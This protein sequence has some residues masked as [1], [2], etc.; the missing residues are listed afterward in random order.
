MTAVDREQVLAYRLAGHHLHE[1]T[2]A[3]TAIAA[4]GLQESPPGWAPVAL[5]ARS[6]DALPTGRSVALVNAMRNAPHYVPRA[7]LAVFT[8][9]IVPPDDELKRFVGP[10]VAK[11][12]AA[13]GYG[14]R[15][16]LDLVAD[17]ARDALADGPLGRDDLHQAFRDRL[18]PELLAWCEGCSSHHLRSGLWR[19]LGP[20]GVTEMPQKAT[21]A[22]VE[23]PTTPTL[24][25]ARDELARRFLRCFGPATH[26]E[27]A[28][29][30]ETS[31]QHAKRLIT[32]LGDEAEQVTLDGTKRWVLAAEARRLAAPPR[33]R[34]VRLL[35]GFDPYVSQPDRA[36]LVPDKALA[37]RLFP[38]VGRP[39]VV[40]DDGRMVG[41]WKSRKRGTA[42]EVDV[43]ALDG[44]DLPDLQGEADA[45]A[46]ARGCERAEVRRP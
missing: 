5:R 46:V 13:A 18:P 35:G 29:W 3:L 19:G 20:Y 15:Q 24:R 10:L 27:L 41:L 14:L 7:D 8:V 28:A 1:R 22:L 12:T 21:W 4:C 43:A 25:E 34:G 44:A 33:A 23:R 39:G 16:A 37:K 11:E 6:T 30:A 17:A 40:L 42:L 31:P 9:A 36:T 2:D 45:V 38:P 32:G 26:T